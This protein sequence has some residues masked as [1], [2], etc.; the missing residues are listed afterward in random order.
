MATRSTTTPSPSCR[1]RSARAHCSGRQAQ[2]LHRAPDLSEPDANPAL[3]GAG[4]EPAAAVHGGL[5]VKRGLRPPGHRR[6]A[7]RRSSSS[8]LAILV[9]SLLDLQRYVITGGSMTGHDPEGVR[10]STRES[11]R[12]TSSGRATSSRSTRPACRRAVTHRIIAVEQG[13]DGGPRVPH[14]GRLQ[15]SPATR[16]TRS[17]STSRSRRATCSTCRCSAT[18]WRRSACGAC[19]SR[20]SASPALLIALS[21]L[22]SLWREAGEEVARRFEDD[23]LP[24]DAEE[25]GVRRRLVLLAALAAVAL[26]SLRGRSCFLAPRTRRAARARS[27][28]PSTRPATGSTSTLRPRYPATDPDGASGYARRRGVNGVPGPLAASGLSEAIVVDMGDFPDKKIT[29]DFDRVFS[30]KTPVDV[31]GYVRHADQGHTQR[32]ARSIHGRGPD[33]Q[34]RAHGLRADDGWGPDRRPDGEP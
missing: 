33:R 10:S 12:P 34:P 28:H 7:S 18:C 4:H 9:P 15:R 3:Q 14:Q 26:T 5:P 23:G 32:A 16:G 2:H 17:R 30:I 19:A 1:R 22:W 20:S 21:L 31:P 25:P 29:V 27:L 13:P 6:S 8:S 11:P 24:H